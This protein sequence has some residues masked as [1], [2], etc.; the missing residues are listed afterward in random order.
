MS[1]LILPPVSSGTGRTL[2]LEG[3]AAVLFGLRPG[4]ALLLPAK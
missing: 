2:I 4:T 1:R 3:L